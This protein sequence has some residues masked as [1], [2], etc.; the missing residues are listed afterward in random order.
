MNHKMNALRLLV[1]ECGN[2]D[3]DVLFD[4]LEEEMITVEGTMV[5]ENKNLSAVFG[6]HHRSLG[7]P[8]GQKVLRRNDG[9]IAAA[10]RHVIGLCIGI[11]TDIDSIRENEKG[12]YQMPPIMNPLDPF[13]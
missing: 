8:S 4:G 3:Q 10:A 13:M 11:W 2:I 7:F 6:K 5:Y 12:D 1:I 9:M